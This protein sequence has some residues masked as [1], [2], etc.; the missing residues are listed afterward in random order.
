MLCPVDDERR[1]WSP[2]G[3]GQVNRIEGIFRKFGMVRRQT[4]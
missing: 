2:G 4:R 3:T 1:G